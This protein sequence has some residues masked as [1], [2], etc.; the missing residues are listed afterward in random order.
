MK[1]L[2]ILFIAILCTSPYAQE[3][4]D[5]PSWDI[6][7]LLQELQIRQ[8]QFPAQLAMPMEDEKKKEMLIA[9][10]KGHDEYADQ[11][12]GWAESLTEY[13]LDP[14][15][16][17]F[18][19][20]PKD[21]RPEFL[22]KVKTMQES[23][24][25]YNIK[26]LKDADQLSIFYKFEYISLLVK[27]IEK[28]PQEV[29]KAIQDNNVPFD[30]VMGSVVNHPDFTGGDKDLYEGKVFVDY[31]KVEGATNGKTIALAIDKI[32]A[33][34]SSYNTTLHE[35]FHAYEKRL[36]FP[37]SESDEF[38]AIHAAEK[39]DDPYYAKIPEEALAEAFAQYFHGSSNPHY[40]QVLLTYRPKLYGYIQ[41]LFEQKKLEEPL[42]EQPQTPEET[43]TKLLQDQELHEACNYTVKNNHLIGENLK[44]V[45]KD[46]DDANKKD[47]EYLAKEVS[48]AFKIACLE[49]RMMNGDFTPV[50]TFPVYEDLK[51]KKI[52]KDQVKFIGK[53]RFYEY[54]E[55]I[56][57]SDISVALKLTAM[58][59]VLMALGNTQHEKYPLY[60][61]YMVNK[62]L[63]K[64]GSCD[65]SIIYCTKI[66]SIV[67]KAGVHHAPLPAGNFIYEQYELVKEKWPNS[68]A[69]Y[70]FVFS[71]KTSFLK[72]WF[73]K[74]G[75]LNYNGITPRWNGH[76]VFNG[77]NKRMSMEDYLTQVRRFHKFVGGQIKFFAKDLEKTIDGEFEQ[78]KKD[79]FDQLDGVD[80]ER[81]RLPKEAKVTWFN[82]LN[83]L[84][85]ILFYADRLGKKS[86]LEWKKEVNAQI[87][88]E[89]EKL[90]GLTTALVN[91]ALVEILLPYR[92]EW[93]DWLKESMGEGPQAEASYQMARHTMK[94]VEKFTQSLLFRNGL[95]RLYLLE[96]D[97]AK[98]SDYFHSAYQWAAKIGT[99]FEKVNS[100]SKL[101][102]KK[103]TRRAN[104]ESFFHSMGEFE[105]ILFTGKCM[106]EAYSPSEEEFVDI[107]EN[108][109]EKTKF[110]GILSGYKYDLTQ[111][112]NTGEHHINSMVFAEQW[113]RIRYD[114]NVYQTVTLPAIGGV[115]MLLSASVS[116]GISTAIMTRMGTWAAGS[117][118]NVETLVS[119]LLLGSITKH[120]THVFLNAAFFTISMKA[121]FHMLG[122][123]KF[124]DP[125]KSM[126]DNYGK[127]ILSG[128]IVFSALPLFKKIGIFMAEGSSMIL[129]GERTSLAAKTI[130]KSI[131]IGGDTVAFTSIDV[132]HRMVESILHPEIEIW[133]ED[134]F[135]RFNVVAN[136]ALAAAI[137]E[138][139]FSRWTHNVV[140]ILFESGGMQMGYGIPKEVLQQILK[141]QP[142]TNPPK[143][144]IPPK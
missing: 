39:W 38:L 14:N 79:F 40:T 94:G 120:I 21:Q 3:E 73:F 30:L 98:S 112:S 1:N 109:V 28:A 137:F 32:F 84:Q 71:M 102:E 103:P 55:E 46:Y 11:E 93:L 9:I 108:M 92:N 42:P 54:F 118:L 24:A 5:Y 58:E 99:A 17:P 115:V 50:G 80:L 82:A 62:Y 144:V 34:T 63:K 23:M 56:L 20:F 59:K 65:K 134:N 26:F 89:P 31:T 111:C 52:H 143:P 53:N 107:D 95:D 27:E 91:Y 7:R 128:A 29:I 121:Q 6:P 104:F 88:A 22:E 131:L 60:F 90:Q 116:A 78:E 66:V 114:E 37:P 126:W 74:M 110:K 10:L 25:K 87:A 138:S 124:Y 44:K 127:P 123:Q 68:F 122:L 16:P 117:L 47:V 61:R 86:P 119:K 36:L 97:L 83:N 8:I 106:G 101:A 140:D 67:E 129:L 76:F 70:T 136:S 18:N 75:G 85:G 41:S 141:A 96:K 33:R 13:G 49:M 4:T 2:L 142:P 57:T 35:M 12:K 135:E 72:A 77:E 15:V 132:A 125:T 48:G 105:E 45:L 139:P 130:E 133:G 43:V 100:T 51:S 69:K 64:F 19:N 81:V 113:G